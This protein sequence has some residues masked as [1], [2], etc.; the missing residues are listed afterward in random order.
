MIVL[1]RDPFISIIDELEIDEQVYDDMLNTSNF[2]R[3]LGYK[4]NGNS[5]PTNIRTSSTAHT[6]DK[7]KSL[8]YHILNI[9]EK[10]FKHKYE[11]EYAEA[12]QLTR[13]EVGQEYK[14]HW[15]YFNHVGQKVDQDRDRKATVILYLNDDFLGGET[16]FDRLNITVTPKKGTALYFTYGNENTKELTYHAGLPV[17]HG[18]KNIATFWI[19]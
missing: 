19:R 14:S 9:L 1:H 3:S 15:D 18:I 4:G 6:G 8:N 17:R 5:S 7:Y 16:N 12:C 11:V 13:Y 2:Q 10:R